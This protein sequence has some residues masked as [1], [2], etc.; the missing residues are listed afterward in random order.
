[1]EPVWQITQLLLKSAQ[2]IETMR[3]RLFARGCRTNREQFLQTIRSRT[4]PFS[5]FWARAS[6]AYRTGKAATAADGDEQAGPKTAAQLAEEVDA[7]VHTHLDNVL[8]V[9]AS[10]SRT[11]LESYYGVAREFA[12]ELETILGE[13]ITMCDRRAQGLKYPPPLTLQPQLAKARSA[14][15]CLLPQLE[16]RVERIQQVVRERNSDI[17]SLAEDIRASWAEAS[18]ATVQTKLARAAHKDF[19][20]RMRRIEHQQQIGVIGWAMRE[21]EHLLTAPDV[22]A[23]VVDC[24]ELLMTEA[25]I[26]ERAVGQVF[27]RKLEPTTEDLREQRQDIIDDFTEG[28]L[29]GREELAGI[30]GKLMLK[31]AWR[32]LEANIS[33]QRQKALLNEGGGGGGSSGKNKKNKP[34]YAAGNAGGGS[35]SAVAAAAA[36]A[37]EMAA[38]EERVL[39]MADQI[40][41]ELLAAED[42]D[43][44]GGKKR[45]KNKKKK[46]KKGKKAGKQPVSPTDPSGSKAGGD[47]DDDEDDD[48][49]DDA[50]TESVRDPQNPFA[51]L[52][53]ANGGDGADE[54]DA[55]GGKAEPWPLP[56]STE[57]SAPKQPVPPTVEPQPPAAAADVAG[58]DA[59]AAAEPQAPG[60]PK[61]AAP[62]SDDVARASRSRRGTNAARY[63][64]GVGF[65]S[66]DGV[67]ATS[68]QL[69][70]SPSLKMS[71]GG[72]ATSGPIRAQATTARA[73][74]VNGRMSPMGTAR[75][76]S[77][78]SRPHS[79]LVNAAAPS[80]AASD[81]RPGSSLSTVA[82]VPLDKEALASLQNT[83]LAGPAEAMERAVVGLGYDNLVSLTISALSER[84]RLTEVAA[85]WH[86][87]VNSVLQTYEAIASQMESF[88]GLCEAHDGEAARLTALLAQAAQDAQG[89]HD[90]YDR[91]ADELRQLKASRGGPTQ[92]D[93]S[94]QP[95]SARSDPTN[96]PAS[97]SSQALP[98]DLQSWGG[99]GP[100][101]QQFQLGFGSVIGAQ[102]G[103]G[104]FGQQFPGLLPH[105]SGAGAAS[106]MNTPS[107]AAAHSAADQLMRFPASQAPQLAGMMLGAGDLSAPSRSLDGGPLAATS[108]LLTA[109]NAASHPL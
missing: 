36:V 47:D 30:I 17:F 56:A 88:K 80:V 85:T 78:T 6:E 51:T 96:E 84:R 3:V 32:I 2:R 43:A 67:N 16:A 53:W 94:E 23:V 86:G 13:C 55:V 24:L 41:A 103:G 31:E 83:L 4:Q 40:D 15:A 34:P 105:G 12:R 10:W 64:P 93:T 11:F 59:E 49:E 106:F 21:L 89:W 50:D 46:A 73:A 72:S 108:S 95:S 66:D 48:D 79:P 60:V 45:R 99:F 109:L 92:R 69:I 62:A 35:Q 91:L 22:A 42:G 82:P 18:G 65:V 8:E 54:S 77:P 38:Q 1:M 57:T 44:A 71:P 27:V 5:E 70:A 87:S 39:A 29:T 14:V 9:S 19:R 74:A 100:Q 68:P 25:E 52:T 76:V 26:L 33:L 28:L 7:L 102:Y 63:V 104:G 20:K 61:T 90:R 58:S 81:R 101:Q 107:F 75:L 98:P 37:V 97:P